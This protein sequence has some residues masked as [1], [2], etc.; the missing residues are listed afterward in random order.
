MSTVSLDKGDILTHRGEDARGWK[1][2]ALN[3]DMDRYKTFHPKSLLKMLEQ[4]YI[5]S[6][7]W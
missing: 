7:K 6:C 1:K 3:G 4:G 2:Y 5:E